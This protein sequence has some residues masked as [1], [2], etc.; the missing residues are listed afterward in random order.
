MDKQ[1]PIFTERAECQDCYKCVRGCPVKAIKLQQGVASV[2]A[3]SCIYCGTCVNICPSGAKQVRNDLRKVKHVLHAH[4]RVIA[5]VAPSWMS[6]FPGVTPGMLVS[7]LKRLGFWNA[8]E[9]ALGAQEVSA[10]VA[11]LL[12]DDP[13]ACLISSACPVVVEYIKKYHPQHVDKL[14]GLVS[15]MMA[16]ASLL[17]QRY[18]ADI[19]VVFIGPCIAKKKEADADEGRIAAVLTFEDLRSWLEAEYLFPVQRVRPTPDDA[20]IPDAAEE[21]ALYPIDGGMIA[22]IKNNCAIHDSQCMSLSGME[23]VADVLESLDA[24]D[25]RNS[26]L[27][28]ELLAC[29]G[30]CINGPKT[31]QR[32]MTLP[33]RLRILQQARTPEMPGPR[34][35]VISIDAIF[36]SEAIAHA[37]FS[38]QQIREVLR[39]T[40][41]ISKDDELN[42]GG[43]G[44]NSCREFALAVLEVKAETSMCVSYMRQL[45]YKKANKLIKSMPSAVVIVDKHLRIIECNR[46]FVRVA[47]PEAEEIFDLHEGLSGAVLDRVLPISHLFK[48]VLESGQDILEKELHINERILQCSLFSIEE[49]SIVG[50]ILYDITEPVMKKDEITHRAQQVIRK[51][52]KTVQKIAYLLGENA[53]ETEMTLNSIIEAFNAGK[54]E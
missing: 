14:T 28:L 24:L 40:G 37:E 4:S 11:R 42:C 21:G 10:H 46:N 29:S 8:S 12:D 36:Q 38:E 45:A 33:K 17:K 2:M 18:G 51:N 52:L 41:K 16:H 9:T 34:S 35:P 15:P 25:A 13:K 50:G 53:A 30:G 32:A 27:F 48:H 44:Y 19:Q 49:G 3:E 6:E 47:G 5:S 20:F 26:G 23:N 54:G 31:H 22:S 43:C 1:Q 39:Q 7:A